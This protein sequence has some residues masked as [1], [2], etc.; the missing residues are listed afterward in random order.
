MAAKF[1]YDEL[2]EK[3][4]SLSLREQSLLLLAVGALIYFLADAWVFA[5]QALREQALLDRQKAMQQQMTV[6][7]AEIAAVDKAQRAENLAE[8]QAELSQLKKQA[9]ALD[10][11]VKSVSVDVP[12]LRPVVAS[13]MGSKATPVK[14]VSL[15]TVAVKPLPSQTKPQPAGAGVTSLSPAAVYKYGVD[16]EL[17]GS[18]LDLMTF[19]AS[20]EATYPKLLW[21]EATLTAGQYPETTLRVSVFF[22]STRPH[23]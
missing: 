8:K 18:Y 19:L 13:M 10:N 22:L 2:R 16:A 11:I 6:L 3:L 7:A 21:S 14:A 1:S 9:A 5:P 23:F 17:R 15:K 20:L 12:N 4:Q